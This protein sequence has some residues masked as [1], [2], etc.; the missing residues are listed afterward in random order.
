[1]KLPVTLALLDV[2]AT[3]IEPRLISLLD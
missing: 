1:F 2:S 3:S